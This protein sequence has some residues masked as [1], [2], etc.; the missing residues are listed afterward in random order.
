[1]NCCAAILAGGPSKRIRKDKV[2]LDL[3]GKPLIR[4]VYDRI[5]D[6]V[7]EIIVVVD[8]K[9]KIN[10]YSPALPR[11]RFVVDR[12]DVRTPLAGASTAF[13]ESES[14]CTLLLPCDTPFLS[15]DL[16]SLLIGLSRKHEAVIPRWPNGYLEPLQAAYN[17]EKGLTAA[18]ST[19]A[20]GKLDM[21]SMIRGLRNVLYL[22][23]MAIQQVDPGLDTFF[24]VNT[25]RDLREAERRIQLKGRGS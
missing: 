17:T 7:D 13:G 25:E 16:A 19:L 5:N 20:E 3:A 8:T 1:L 23:T 10:S 24:N 12:Y 22:S 21:A 6:V 4:H 2:L 14:D 9:E 18:N 15:T 11:A